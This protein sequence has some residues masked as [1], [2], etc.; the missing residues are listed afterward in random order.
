MEAIHPAGGQLIGI[1]PAARFAAVTTRLAPGQ[2]LLLYTD[3]LTEA[4]TR[5]GHMLTEDDLTAYLTGLS[6]TNADGLIAAL[7]DLLAD[8]G[9]RPVRRHRPA[10][11]DRARR[12]GHPPGVPVTHPTEL[13]ISLHAADPRATRLTVSG[14]LD[15]T[16]APRLRAALDEVHLAPGTGLI[17]DLSGLIF[18]DSSG[19]SVLVAAHH[20]TLALTSRQST[21]GRA[22]D[23]RG[24]RGLQGRGC[25]APP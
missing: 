22:P 14:E 19:I 23:G 3:G 25:S 5:S 7:T 13:T 2:S 11:P 12:H 20:R 24:V 4:R 17:I 21:T 6:P 18:C 9:G 15:Y 10:R 8:M 16:S 1:L